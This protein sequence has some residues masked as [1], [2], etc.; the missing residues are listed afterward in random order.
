MH[1][2]M[3][4]NHGFRGN[5][6]MGADDDDS[7]DDSDGVSDGVGDGDGAD[8]AESD[9]EGEYISGNGESVYVSIDL[10]TDNIVF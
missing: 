1:A 3:G 9:D 5:M 7:D 8:S 6:G 4:L 2:P 10:I